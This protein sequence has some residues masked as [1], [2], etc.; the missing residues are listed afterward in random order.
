MTR[1]R[2]EFNLSIAEVGSNDAWRQSELGMAIVVNDVAYG[3]Q[4]IDKA[5]R[6]IELN[7]DVLLTDIQT[8]T[9]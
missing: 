3:H 5:I 8:E 6:K 7:P 1:L 4:V 9:Y 2:N